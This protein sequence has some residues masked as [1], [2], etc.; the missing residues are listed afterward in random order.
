[1]AAGESQRCLCGV[2]SAL[3]GGTWRT[4]GPTCSFAPAMSESAVAWLHR[5]PG[6]GGAKRQQGAASLPLGIFP[7]PHCLGIAQAGGI[8]ELRSAARVKVRS[9]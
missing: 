5:G 7:R 6:G 4:K 8:P 3:K 9:A 1:M 2:S